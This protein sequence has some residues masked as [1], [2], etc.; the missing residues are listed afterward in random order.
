MKQTG[1]LFIIIILLYACGGEEKPFARHE[2]VIKEEGFTTDTMCG[3]YRRYTGTVAG[4][5]VVLHYMQYHS[6]V[7]CQYYYV[8]EGRNIHIYSTPNRLHNNPLVLI[9]FPETEREKDSPATWQ[10][11]ITGD[12]MKGE[13]ISGNGETTYP[14]L[15]KEDYSN[16][17][18]QFSIVC[19]TDSVN[20]IDSLPEPKAFT[21]YEVLLPVGDD[22]GTKFVR[23]AIY[24]CIGCDT[25]AGDDMKSCLDGLKSKY[26]ADYRHV[27]DEEKK[28]YTTATSFGTWAEETN[29]WIVYNDDGMLVVN[30]HVDTYTGGAHSIYSSHYLCIDSRD[31]KLLK[32]EDVL[33]A[34][35]AQIVRLLEQ[36]ARKLYNIANEAPLYENMLTEELYIPEQFYIS[37]KGITFVY[38]IYEVA[39]YA[40]GEISLF[41]PYNKIMGMLTPYFKQRMKLEQLA[42][43]K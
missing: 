8:Q 42:A 32:L 28:L 24:N 3:V 31:K 34:D 19:M 10:V 35:T 27:S 39:A 38:G 11:A 18:Q 40:D 37:N 23:T 2:Q 5:P 16:G 30:H 7:T 25:I 1:L 29:F 20:F 4:Q 21:T 36:E 41:I 22:E 33:Q 43:N 26:F 17:T 14:I 13:W 9:E 6:M 15:L 12:S